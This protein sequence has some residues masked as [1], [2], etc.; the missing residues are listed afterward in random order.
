LPNPLP[1]STSGNWC[2]PPPASGVQT[3]VNEKPPASGVQTSVN[4][5][6]VKKSFYELGRGQMAE[7]YKGTLDGHLVAIKMFFKKHRVSEEAR[8]CFTREA[9][10][11]CRCIH[12]NIV[13]TFG[14]NEE[15]MFL[16]MGI[17]SLR[18]FF[19]KRMDWVFFSWNQ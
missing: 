5:K 17:F 1:L 13:R 6:R 4:E 14:Y 9:D 10:L 3:S 12:P 18:D 19:Q 7:V 11:A 8:K 16:C 2:L 15:K